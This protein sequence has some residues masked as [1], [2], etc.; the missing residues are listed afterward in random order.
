MFMKTWSTWSIVAGILMFSVTSI[1]HGLPRD[2]ACPDELKDVR[3][4][5]LKQVERGW[6]PGASI[7]VM[8]RGKVIWAEG[9]GYADIEKGLK[10]DS[11]TVYLLAS[12]SKPI[13]A[14][15]L[16]QLVDKGHIDLDKPVNDYLPAT[17]IRAFVGDAEDI[18]VRRLLSH[19]GGLPTHFTFYYDGVS[20]PSMDDTIGRYGRATY[21]PGSR[22]NYSNLGFGILNY[23]VEV[24]SGQSWADYMV[25]HVYDP[26]GMF[27]TSDRVRPERMA[28]RAQIYTHDAGRR[29][30]AVNSYDF[31]HPGAS[32]IWSSAHDLA[33]FCSMHINGGELDGV[34]VLSEKSVMA[35]REA[36]A[37]FT[38]YGLGW[39]LEGQSGHRSFMH[40]GG[41]PGVSTQIQ[42]WT[43][44]DV[45]VVALTNSDTSS[46][47]GA[48]IGR[49]RKILIPD[50][51]SKQSERKRL[52]KAD[53]DSYVGSWRGR[54]AH[55]DGDI[56]IELTIAK[57][58]ESRIRFGDARS[59]NIEE[60]RLRGVV[61]EGIVRGIRLRV[62]DGYHGVVDLRFFL[63]PDNA[64]GLSGTVFATAQDYFGVSFWLTLGVSPEN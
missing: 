26:L 39:E 43:E 17:K 9:F 40:S 49:I 62:H 5:I 42:A 25:E 24:V 56:P 53:R 16:M 35:M 48:V 1:S 14:T 57:D 20:P 10:A 63:E 44:D 19:T 64:G 41:M 50:E 34:R 27:G 60:V 18:T 36:P 3:L 31:D 15:G 7:V 37:P 2:V 29:F 38:D 32:A 52:K 55:F 21:P 11:N 4:T 6:V 8:K 33:R 54:L 28:D 13:T 51:H 61:F 58:L 47:V 23:L 59:M 46:L 30:V 45:V 12:V 22:Y